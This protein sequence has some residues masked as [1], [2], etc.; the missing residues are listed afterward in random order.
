MSNGDDAG[1]DVGI[2]EVADTAIAVDMVAV[3]QVAGMAAATVVIVAVA[4][5]NLA[6]AVDIFAVSDVAGMAAIAAATA[7]AVNTMSTEAG[8]WGAVENPLSS[9]AGLAAVANLAAVM[10]VVSKALP[11][12]IVGM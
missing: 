10:G 4:N 3:T 12:L 9:G 1:G 2:A 11:I 5:A 8:K 6:T 7:V